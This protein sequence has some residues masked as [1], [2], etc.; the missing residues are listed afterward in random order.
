M[1]KY[2]IKVSHNQTRYSPQHKDNWFSFWR[3]YESFDG[4]DDW[5][6]IYFTSKKECEDFLR[7]RI[8]EDNEENGSSYY[9][10]IK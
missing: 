10:D 5:F 9:I 7:D 8:K 4:W 2:R 3:T 1:R 6:P